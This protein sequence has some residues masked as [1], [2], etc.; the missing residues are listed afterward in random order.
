[1]LETC[2]DAGCEVAPPVEPP[3]VDGC[4]DRCGAAGREFART[5][6]SSDDERVIEMKNGLVYLRPSRLTY[7]RRTG[8][9]ET[10]IPAAWKEMMG[11]L[12]KHGLHSAMNRGYGLLRDCPKN[13][14]PEK[15]RFDACVDLDPLFEERAIRE[16]GAQTLPGGSYLRVR[17]VGSY[18]DLQSKLATYH[19]VFEPPAGL[20]L[21]ERRPLVTVYLDSPARADDNLRADICVP[22][23]VASGRGEGD[24]RAA[25]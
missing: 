15:L 5:C 22:V 25:A 18:A 10:S 4:A 13:V 6:I 8:S 24:G 16:L 19:T 1:M 3:P 21:D 7:V 14:A 20:K 11:W 23:S 17:N 9:Y 2:V 12:S